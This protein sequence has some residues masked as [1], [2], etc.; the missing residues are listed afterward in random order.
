MVF[1][2]LN[3]LWRTRTGNCCVFLFTYS[4]SEIPLEYWVIS[5]IVGKVWMRRLQHRWNRKK[6]FRSGGEIPGTSFVNVDLGGE[7]T[8]GV[9]LGLPLAWIAAYSYLRWCQRL[10]KKGDGSSNWK[11][12]WR[13]QGSQVNIGLL[14]IF[15]TSN[16]GQI[17]YLQKAIIEDY[18]MLPRVRQAE[19][20][21]RRTWEVT[22]II[23]LTQ[24][25][26]NR[27]FQIWLDLCWMSFCPSRV[28]LR[29]SI[30]S[31]EVWDV[32]EVKE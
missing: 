20:N 22:G 25:G 23:H 21:S 28:L 15:P 7:S 26:M 11:L 16:S 30:I 8:L 4:S 24:G 3:L 1:T 9:C 19:K 18:L 17:W 12:I 29:F 31:D 6:R 13:S 5:Y 10:C 2:F 27:A 14:C 32:L